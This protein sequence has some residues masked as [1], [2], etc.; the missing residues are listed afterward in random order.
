MVSVLTSSVIDCGYV[1]VMVSVL[2]SSA[3]D[4]GY[5]SVMVSVLTSRVIDC[6]YE[7]RSGHLAGALQRRRLKC[8]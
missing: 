4:C 7:P 2:T 6:G 8:E 5:V 1:S 3:I